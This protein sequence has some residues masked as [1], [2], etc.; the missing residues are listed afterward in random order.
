MCCLHTQPPCV[1]EDRSSVRSLLQG[2]SDGARGVLSA[3]ASA[4]TAGRADQVP[5]DALRA[6]HSLFS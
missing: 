3:Q 5:G 1:P 2:G 6:F 4:S